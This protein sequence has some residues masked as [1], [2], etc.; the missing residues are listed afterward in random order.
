MEIFYQF[1]FYDVLVPV[2]C[3]SVSWTLASHLVFSLYACCLKNLFEV[4]KITESC[5]I[6]YYETVMWF[7]FFKGP[8]STFKRV[9]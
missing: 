7:G 5:T 1:L 6:A 4:P 2:Q 3:I 9:V 8:L